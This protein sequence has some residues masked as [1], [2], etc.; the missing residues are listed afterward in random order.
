MFAMGLSP[1]LSIF[2]YIKRVIGFEAF[3]TTRHEH[4]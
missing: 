3:G 4:V 1:L 2:E